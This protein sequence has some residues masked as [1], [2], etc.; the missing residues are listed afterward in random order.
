[1]GGSESYARGLLGAFDGRDR[2]VVL[3]N[4]SVMR[5]YAD[6]VR[7]PAELHHVRSY[8]TGDAAPA[9]ALAMASARVLP[10]LVARGLPRGLDVVH[11]PLTV[12]VPAVRG[13]PT[14]VTLHDVQHL[15]LPEFFSRTERAYRR[16]AYDGAARG[17]TRVVTVSEHGR[18]AA[19]D[20]L[21]LDPE[22]VRAIH[23]GIDHARFNPD[24]AGD[25]L[26]AYGL[27]ERFILYPANLWPHKNH[28]RLLEALARTSDRELALV[29][30]GEDYGRRERLLGRAREL[31]VAQRVRHLGYV[32]A[33]TVPAL[34]RAATALVFP[35][36]YE[37][38]GGPPV[39]AMACGCPVAASDAASVPEV[40]GGAALHFDPREVDAMAAAIDA[41]AGDDALR[42][43]LRAAGR[44]RAAEF[45]WARAAA[46][47]AEVY[48]DAA[49]G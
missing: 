47:H 26:G 8:R 41:I 20:R 5:A 35:T 4:A 10:R 37:G 14:V 18:R 12:P 45:T 36:L 6:R 16:W 44:E 9:R 25:D 11:Y 39:E 30:T 38:F 29:L 15:E 21:G 13:L 3:A 28:D 17:A 1:V 49:G 32:P 46:A 24:A 34:Y 19:I 43:R 2:V 48:R 31:G 40:C 7:P 42:R 22:R 33:A 23:W 27:P